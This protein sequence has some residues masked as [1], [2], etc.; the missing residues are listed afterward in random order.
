MKPNATTYRLLLLAMWVTPLACAEGLSTSFADIE[1]GNVV[2]GRPQ[3]VLDQAGRSLTIKNL[4]A[5]PVRV[6]ID[7]LVPQPTQLRSGAQPIPDVRWMEARPNVV[8]LGAHEE[9]ECEIS[10]HVPRK[11]TFRAQY[12]QA[13]IWS[14]GVPSDSQGMTISAGL[15]SR[16]RFRTKE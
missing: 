14:H 6:V 7:V 9:K 2:L 10:L 13:M 1:V 3:K 4:G 5:T 12:Y 16:V 11:K 8:V 15:L